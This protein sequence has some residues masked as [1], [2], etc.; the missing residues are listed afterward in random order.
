VSAGSPPGGGRAR[1]DEQP[2]RD[3]PLV[4][5]VPEA[6]AGVR[7]DRAVAILTGVSRSVAA[8]LVEAGRVLVAGAPVAGRSLP[9]AAGDELEVVLP[10]QPDQ[11]VVPD[12][13]VPFEVVHEDP[14]LIVVEK[15]AGVVVHPG[16]GRR[17]GTLVN[18]LVASYPDIAVLGAGP[19]DPARPGIV[20]RI[21]RGTSGLLVV[22]RTAEAYRSLAAQMADRSVGRRYLALVAGHLPDDR[23]VVDAPI[24]RSARTPTRMSVSAGG[25]AARTHYVVVERLGGTPGAVRGRDR[26]RDREGF[27]GS[28]PALPAATLVA[29]TLETGRTH[30]VRVHFAAIGHP[31]VGDDRYGVGGPL[32][33]ARLLEPGRLFLHAAALAFDHPAD[34]ERCRW[35]SPLPEDLAGVIGHVP[36]LPD[37]DELGGG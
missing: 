1:S 15:P 10:G 28:P 20:H 24:G 30:Q 7:V 13:A 8:G 9:L 27:S 2:S 34:G 22:A 25:R 29:C 14:F 37:G 33:G 35:V 36:E 31:V 26:D 11:G 19:C 12:P 4:A 17:T 18:G 16:A 3:G 32:A 6:L 21:D 5:T 23:G